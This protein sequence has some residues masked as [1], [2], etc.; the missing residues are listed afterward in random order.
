MLKHDFD[1][2]IRLNLLTFGCGIQRASFLSTKSPRPQNIAKHIQE[3]LAPVWLQPQSAEGG[4]APVDRLFALLEKACNEAF[5]F[6]ILL[7][8]SRDCYRRE[9]PARQS[10]LRNDSEAQS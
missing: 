1:G 5:E 9:L 2:S 4:K 6:A 10:P 7:R 8:S 3:E